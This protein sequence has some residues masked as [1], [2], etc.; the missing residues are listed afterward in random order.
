MCIVREG[1]REKD[2]PLDYC[3]EWTGWAAAEA[4]RWVESVAMRV[5]GHGTGGREEQWFGLEKWRAM[6]YKRG[7]ERERGE[8]GPTSSLSCRD[9]TERDWEGGGGERRR[10][11]LTT[12]EWPR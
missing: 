6:V 1:G 3:S 5:S 11:G 8:D 4:C 2:G 7:G 9:D 12:K 10:R